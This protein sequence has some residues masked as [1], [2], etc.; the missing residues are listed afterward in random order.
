RLS[1]QIAPGLFN[2]LAR[3]MLPAGCL[4]GQAMLQPVTVPTTVTGMRHRSFTDSESSG[5]MSFTEDNFL[6]DPAMEQVGSRLIGRSE[7]MRV[8]LENREME[9]LEIDVDA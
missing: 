4:P 6:E 9:E 5:Y 3:G 2:P 8:M 7:M 1:P